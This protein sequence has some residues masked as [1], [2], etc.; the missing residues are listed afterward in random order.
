MDLT[1]DP[2]TLFTV[3]GVL[4]LAAAI[5]TMSVFFMRKYHA[6]VSRKKSKAKT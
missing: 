2:N 4:M 3:F 5:F 1:E 6:A